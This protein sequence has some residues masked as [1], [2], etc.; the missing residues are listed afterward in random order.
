MRD[1]FVSARLVCFLSSAVL[2]APVLALAATEV[3]A[4]AQ[5]AQPLPPQ[6]R[7]QI[8]TT[9]RKHPQ[10][11]VSETLWTVERAPFYGVPDHRQ[12]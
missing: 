3:T 1:L 8:C 9:W 5:Q 6:S 12:R 10:Q 7:P 11:Q 2:L 4:T